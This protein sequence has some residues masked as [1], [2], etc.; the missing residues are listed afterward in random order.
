[1]RLAGLLNAKTVLTAL[2]AAGVLLIAVEVAH[3]RST[4][5]VPIAAPCQPRAPLALGGID[6]TIQQVVLAGL[7]RAACRLDV[8]REALV[9]AIGG[10]PAAGRVHWSIPTINAAVRAGLLGA[11]AEAN[12]RGDVPGF[13]YP[14]LKRLIRHAPIEQLM[15]GGIALGN[16]FG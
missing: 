12:R 16:L 6:G 7:D 13:A 1:V 5:P 8:S 11:L 15:Q 3:G 9:L 4:H 14:L 10:N 2:V